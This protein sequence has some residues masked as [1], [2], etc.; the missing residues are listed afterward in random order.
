MVGENVPK[1]SP[2]HNDIVIIYHEYI[3]TL[4]LVYL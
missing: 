4:T 2:H 3:I 1:S